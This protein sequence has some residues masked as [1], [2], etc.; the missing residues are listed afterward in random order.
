[1]SIIFSEICQYFNS[2]IKDEKDVSAG[3]AA[4]R[5][6]L[7]VLEYSK[8]KN[9]LINLKIKPKDSVYVYYIFSFFFQLKP[10]KSLD[11]AC[12]MQ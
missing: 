8:C 1:M 12:K 3:M 5:T 9:M 11:I 4:I 6:L 7:K 10:F 2:I